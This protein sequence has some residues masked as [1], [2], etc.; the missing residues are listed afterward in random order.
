MA[1]ENLY[2][3]IYLNIKAISFR[4]KS[5]EKVSWNGQTVNN[6]M[7]NGKI[8][9]CMVKEYLNGLT[10]EY[11]PANMYKIKNMVMEEL[12][13]LMEESMRVIGSKAFKMDKVK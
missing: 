5:K 12:N 6:M 9:K 7:D 2:G 13:G 11:I 1:M 10:V 4:I 3:L 8:I